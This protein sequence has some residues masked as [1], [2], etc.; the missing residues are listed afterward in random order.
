MRR[1]R[2]TTS[3]L[4]RHFEISLCQL[5]ELQSRGSPGCLM[6]LTEKDGSEYGGLSVMASAIREG[7]SVRT[8]G[9]GAHSCGN[10]SSPQQEEMTSSDVRG[11]Q[12]FCH[13]PI[14]KM[15]L[16]CPSPR[17]LWYS[18]NA[19]SVKVYS[20]QLITS[21]RKQSTVL[22]LKSVHV[23]I[24]GLNFPFAYIDINLD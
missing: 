12:S 15:V 1:F 4:G 9:C 5:N 16:L 13:V 21:V 3:G 2:N 17:L 22:H 7:V 14:P 20:R 10:R 24:N 8:W 18:F 6:N 19:R 23:V 11:S